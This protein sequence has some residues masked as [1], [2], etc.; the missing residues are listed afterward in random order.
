[1]NKYILYIIIFFSGMLLGMYSLWHY[2]TVTELLN[3]QKESEEICVKWR[4]EHFKLS[5][6]NLY[7]EL[8]AQGIDYPKIVLGQA[9]LETG[10]F[11]SYSCKQRN[12]LFG[13]RLKDGTY[14]EFEHWT[15]SVT[16]YKKYIQKYKKVPKDY[17]K[18]L[19]DLGYAED[20]IYI[21]KVKQIVKN[22][23]I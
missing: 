5:N 18:F 16:A 2:Y 6:E 13:L 15:N 23:Q 8:L 1:M 11:Q 9:I 4:S 22:A 20:S 14:M 7:N 10:H 17:Y 12:N 21:I 3:E 19:D